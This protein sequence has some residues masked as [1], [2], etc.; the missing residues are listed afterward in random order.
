MADGGRGHG[1]ATGEI[2]AAARGRV[3]RKAQEL[4]QV[5]Q[6]NRE[7][8]NRAR[9]AVGDHGWGAGHRPAR[10]GHPAVARHRRVGNFE[11]GVD[12]QVLTHRHRGPRGTGG[13][14]RA[15]EQRIRG[16]VDHAQ[17][18]QLEGLQQRTARGFGGRV[19]ARTVQQR[20]HKPGMKGCRARA[21]RLKIRRVVAK[22]PRDGR[23]YLVRGRRRNPRRHR[24]RRRP[25]VSDRLPDPAQI[26]RRCGQNVGCCN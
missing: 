18:I 24:R 19:G 10:N 7:W 4:R 16:R 14:Q 5:R 22:Q 20:L 12:Q 13:D 23:R 11:A 17:Q 2:V 1:S 8:K 3:L 25:G 9:G 15:P 21:E 6:L 26:R